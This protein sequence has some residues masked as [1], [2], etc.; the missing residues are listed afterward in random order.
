MR[1]IGSPRTS[2]AVRVPSAKQVWRRS[3]GRRCDALLEQ[4]RGAHLVEHADPVV[5]A[6][7]VGAQPHAQPARD[8]VDQTVTPSPRNMFEPGQ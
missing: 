6:A 7:A 2:P 4:R 8:E 3:P 1:P 5:G